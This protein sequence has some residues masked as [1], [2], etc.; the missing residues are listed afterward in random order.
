M[1]VFKRKM[2]IVIKEFEKEG[3]IVKIT[4]ELTSERACDW[5]L[6]ALLHMIPKVANNNKTMF[7]VIKQMTIKQ[8]ESLELKEG[9]KWE[10]EKK[11]AH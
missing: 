6:S 5:L 10:D 4:G 11:E 7:D 8:I 9:A 2:K 1:K 3:C